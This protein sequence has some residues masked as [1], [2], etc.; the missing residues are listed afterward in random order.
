[1]FVRLVVKMMIDVTDVVLARGVGK[2]VVA[3]SEASVY[4]MGVQVSNQ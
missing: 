1:M 2:G 3:I 4:V